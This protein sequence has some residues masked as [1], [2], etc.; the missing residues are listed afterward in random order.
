M[1]RG[2]MLSAINVP[3]PSVIDPQ[4]GRFLDRR[5]LL[6]VFQTAGVEV[7]RPVTTTSYVG[8]TACLVAV[9]AVHCGAGDVAVYTGSWTEWAQ[10]ADS[11]LVTRDEGRSVLDVHCQKQWNSSK[12]EFMTIVAET[13]RGALNCDE[14]M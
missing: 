8:N 5:Q 11:R 1:L 12:T 2:H 6:D 14:Q 13:H 3:W 9:A 4:S 10:M 7:N